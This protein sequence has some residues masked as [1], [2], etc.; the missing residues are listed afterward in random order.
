MSYT[1]EEFNPQKPVLVVD[2]QQFDISF[3]TLQ[4]EVTFKAQYGSLNKMFENLKEN[5]Q[6][7]ISVMWEL[8]ID[9]LYFNYS[10]KKFEKFILTTEE[11][12]LDV[13]KKMTACLNDSVAKSMPV[14]KNKKRYKELQDIKKAQSE[15]NADPCYVV[16]Y[17][18]VSKR[19]GY[20]IEQFYELT[21]GQLHKI[22]QVIGDKVYEELE[23][24]AALQGK[25]LKPR[26]KFDD[27]SEEQEEQNDAHALEALKEL[28]RKYKERNKEG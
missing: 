22:L 17:D 9:K 2:D 3:I 25:K 1:V 7:V 26:V 12:L 11:S 19:Y 10:Y 20:T 21:L 24:Q 27:V 4:K 28:Q 8:L 18:S 5:P 16:Y 6:I 23:V 14:I 15:G 13:S